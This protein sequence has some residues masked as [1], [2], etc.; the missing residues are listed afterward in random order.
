[1]K[2]I[3]FSKEAKIII[4]FLLVLLIAI[5]SSVYKIDF[6]KY[7][8]NFNNKI[9]NSSKAT[10]KIKVEFV[11]CIDGDTAKF[12][13]KDNIYTYRFLGINTKEYTKRKEK[14]GLEAS[15]YTCTKLKSANNIYVSYEKNSTHYDNY[16]RHLVWVYVDSKL[17]QEDLLK[18]GLAEVKYVYTNLTYL[19][20]LYKAENIAKKNKLNIFKNY[21]QKVYSDIEYTIIFD[22]NGN[23]RDVNVKKGTVAHIINNP[24][25]EGK[26]FKGWNKD[27]SLYDFSN[28]VTSN[29][30]LEA[31][32][33]DK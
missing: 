15:N 31:V 24:K 14:Y 10:K 23:T 8:N 17:L 7:L 13:E 26:I 19:D 25:E 5:V 3:N 16:G 11:N 32:F 30:M 9:S 29:L 22:N 21:K 20:K 18:N 12:K 6:N 27:G 4:A 1:M 28:P 33:E 2:K